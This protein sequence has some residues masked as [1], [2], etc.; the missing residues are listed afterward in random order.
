MLTQSQ[1]EYVYISLV[2]VF[3]GIFTNITN[4]PHASIAEFSND[5]YETLELYPTRSPC[6]SCEGR[7][8]QDVNRTLCTLLLKPFYYK[9]K[10]MQHY[11]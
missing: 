10:L 6:P 3:K 11:G 4:K 1:R 8:T 9:R 5:L 7:I 2:R